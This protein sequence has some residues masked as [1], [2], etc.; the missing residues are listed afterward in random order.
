MRRGRR[1]PGHRRPAREAPD[2]SGGRWGSRPDAP[3][4]LPKQPPA[5]GSPGSSRERTAPSGSSW[6]FSFTGVAP[7]PLDQGPARLRQ[8]VLDP[9]LLAAERRSDLR[10]APALT[11]FQQEDRA[12]ARQQGLQRL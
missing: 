9:L 11:L 5:A 4:L 8:L 7:P 2:G 6:L 10:D 3:S 12:M 1:T